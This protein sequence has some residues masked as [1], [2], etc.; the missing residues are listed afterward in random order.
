MSFGEEWV[1]PHPV[2]TYS[3]ADLVARVRALLPA[4]IS[5]ALVGANDAR[6]LRVMFRPVDVDAIAAKL[7]SREG[8][9]DWKWRHEMDPPRNADAYTIQLDIVDDEGPVL[10]VHSNDEHNREAWPIAFSIASSL[11]EDLDAEDAFD[12]FEMDRIPMFIAPRK[13]PEK[14]N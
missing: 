9:L 2:E 8:Q 12:P 13:L 7:S 4:G 11:A 6:A 14:P 10:R 1:L 5:V 3:D